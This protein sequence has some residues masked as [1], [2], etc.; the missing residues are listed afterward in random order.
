M[1]S[2]KYKNGNTWSELQLG[3]GG[4]DEYPVGSFYFSPI[5]VYFFAESTASS[6]SYIATYD[7]Q[8]I[9]SPASIFGGNWYEIKFKIS[10]SYSYYNFLGFT[11]TNDTELDNILAITANQMYGLVISPTYNEQITTARS[12]IFQ[13]TPQNMFRQLKANPTTIVKQGNVYGNLHLDLL[14][15]QDISADKTFSTKL[16]GYRAWQRIA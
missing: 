12:N 14:H 10:D 7:L 5:A 16:Y 15:L 6:S 11:S 3:G 9:N 2:L 8:T 4:L 1:P 13:D